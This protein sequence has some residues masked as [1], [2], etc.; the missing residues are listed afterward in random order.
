MRFFVLT[1]ASMA[2]AAQ[3][4]RQHHPPR[5]AAEYAKILEDPKRDSWQLPQMVVTQL[6]LKPEE[7]VADIGAGTGYFARRFSKHAGKVYAVDIDEKLLAISRKDAPANLVTV[8]AAPDDPKL[9]AGGVDTIFFCD[10]L[11]HVENRTAYY[12][13]L[14]KALKP[15]GRVVIVDF[16]KKPLPIG[17]PESMKLAEAEVIAEFKAAGFRLSRTFD[18]L[19]YQYFLEFRATREAAR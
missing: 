13:K 8:L 5:D 11:H 14:E 3:T 16:H 9:P 4:A 19:P 12:R 17:P 10:V 15:G 18:G 6:G 7:V 1:F 2:L